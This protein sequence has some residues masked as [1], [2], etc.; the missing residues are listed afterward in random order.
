MKAVIAMNNSE[1]AHYGAIAQRVMPLRYMLEV[2]KIPGYAH[3]DFFGSYTEEL[4]KEL[5]RHP[6][7]NEI[8][9]MV[10]GGLNHFG[11][12]CSIVEEEMR[13]NGS[14]NTD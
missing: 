13:F 3:Y 1:V 14:V 5:G 4:I 2:R 7:A 9:L 11:A 10:D 8:I 12:S 6:T